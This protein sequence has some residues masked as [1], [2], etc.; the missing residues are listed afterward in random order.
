MTQENQQRV[1]QTMFKTATPD[2][3]SHPR[4]LEFVDEV[5]APLAAK[6][7]RQIGL[8][9]IAQPFRLLD[10]GAGLGVVA[11]LVQTMVDGEVLGKSS[12][13]SADFSEPTVE[14]VRGRIE[15]EG[16]RNTEARVVDAQVGWVGHNRGGGKG[17]ADEDG[18][19]NRVSGR[20]VHACDD[21]YRVSC[22]A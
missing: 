16:W 20:R 5:S 19:E 8:D 15:R 7:L 11:G 9:R 3:I 1:L 2:A 18:L 21:E 13:V 6:M 4:M 10:N 17:V 12:V 14:F 22:R